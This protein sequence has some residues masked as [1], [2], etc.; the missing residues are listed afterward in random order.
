M[1]FVGV[2]SRDC[3]IRGGDFRLTRLRALW[4]PYPILLL[5]YIPGVSVAMAYYEYSPRQVPEKLS[6]P[7]RLS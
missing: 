5:D 4:K 2:V 3:V 6:H 7:K 1:W